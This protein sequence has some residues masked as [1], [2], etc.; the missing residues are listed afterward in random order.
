MSSSSCRCEER[1]ADWRSRVEAQATKQSPV[2]FVRASASD[3][4][5]RSAR[6]RFAMMSNLRPVEQKDFGQQPR[7][8]V[9]FQL[10]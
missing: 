1:R 2:M 5:L 3:F 9:G 10:R 4:V 6:R 7:I 8:D